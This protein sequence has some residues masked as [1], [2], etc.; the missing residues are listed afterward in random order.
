MR[1]FDLATMRLWSVVGSLTLADIDVVHAGTLYLDQQ[2]LFLGSGFRHF[3]ELQYVP[4]SEFAIKDGFQSIS[5]D[6]T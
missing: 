3:S 5:P 6:M 2:L 4:L 1:Q